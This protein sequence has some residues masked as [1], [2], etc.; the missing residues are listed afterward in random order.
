MT[1]EDRSPIFLHSGWRT[2]K[3]WLWSRFRRLPG[4]VCFYEPEGE[5]IARLTPEIVASARA[6]NWPSGHPEDV[7][8]YY[9]EYLPLLGAAQ[10]AGVPGYRESFALRSHLRDT[11]PSDHE[12]EAGE[13]AHFKN[14]IDAA[15]VKDGRAVFGCARTLGRIGSLK[16][17]LGGH[18]L[19]IV[20]D[21]YRQWQSISHQW[22]RHGNSYFIAGYVMIAGQNRSHPLLGPLA[23]RF[24]I[25]EVKGDEFDQEMGCYQLL[26]EKMPSVR[27]YELFLRVQT[28]AYHSAFAWADLLVDVD[29]LAGSRD[30]QKAAGE[31]ITQLTGLSP[32]LSDCRVRPM[33]IAPEEEE[34][35]AVTE[36]FLRDV[37]EG[38]FDA[39]L[40][41]DAPH[42][43]GAKEKSLSLVARAVGTLRTAPRSLR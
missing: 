37:E 15:A 33:E 35:L 39:A 43:A 19:L 42:G 29:A 2:A 21:L 25:P 3:T 30:Q 11:D 4:T 10:G 20:R 41:G 1:A 7:D 6:R 18:H 40:P 34:N 5:W 8:A 26:A 31:E 16:R 14:L 12:R 27:Q 17:H 36:R 13:A 28:A 38:E 22:T 24:G 9:T 32:D 23:S